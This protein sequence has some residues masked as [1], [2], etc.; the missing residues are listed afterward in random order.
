[1][2]AGDPGV[3]A[4]LTSAQVEALLD[5]S[6]YTGLCRAFAERGAARVREISAALTRPPHGSK[7]VG[8][9]P[10]HRPMVSLS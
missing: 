7:D 1:M 9:D 3:S 6:R 5:P 4:R 10:R 2:L 8:D